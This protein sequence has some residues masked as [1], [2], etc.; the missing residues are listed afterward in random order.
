MA[1]L[2]PEIVYRQGKKNRVADVLSQYGVDGIA[3]TTANAKFRLG[4]S[5]VRR[6][7]YEW[8]MWLPNTWILMP[9]LQPLWRL[10]RDNYHFLRSRVASVVLSMVIWVGLHNIYVLYIAVVC[11]VN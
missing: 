8:K 3:E 2:N 10:Y 7:V 1:E 5:S 9:V 11:V 4:D 6:V